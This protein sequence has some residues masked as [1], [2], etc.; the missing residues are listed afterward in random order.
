VSAAEDYPEIARLPSGLGCEVI[1]D[2]EDQADR[3]L[4]ELDRLRDLVDR[5]FMLD[6]AATACDNVMTQAAEHGVPVSWFSW[7]PGHLRQ[8]AGRIA[9]A[10][11]PRPTSIGEA[12]PS[13]DAS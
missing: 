7:V 4:A 11:Q 6:R 9:A 13:E 8:V 1:E 2:L 12:T 5:D 3:V 10:T